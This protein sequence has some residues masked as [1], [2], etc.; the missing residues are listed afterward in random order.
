LPDASRTEKRRL[1]CR[2]RT[3]VPSGEPTIS[4][5]KRSMDRSACDEPTETM[6]FAPS[7][8]TLVIFQ[9]GQAGGPDA[10]PLIQPELGNRPAGMAI[11]F[12]AKTAPSPMSQA[13]QRCARR[14]PSRMPNA[15]D[16]AGA[17]QQGDEADGRL[18]RP[19]LIAKPL[20]D[21]P[22]PTGANLRHWI[23][24]VHGRRGPCMPVLVMNK[25]CRRPPGRVV[26]NHDHC[27][28]DHR[29]CE[30]PPQEGPGAVQEVVRGV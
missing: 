17:V 27:R 16:D 2:V 14:C 11:G 6:M 9:A 25:R 8:Q 28:R 3:S 18:R 13:E 1:Q 29:R 30:A 19:P 24:A 26:S 12:A 7:A 10:I 22:R 20:A 5:R 15:S 23:E 21:R 4:T